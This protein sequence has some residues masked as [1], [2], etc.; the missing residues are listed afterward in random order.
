MELPC[1]TSP[2]AVMG[3]RDKIYRPEEK[4]KSPNYERADARCQPMSKIRRG[5]DEFMAMA[6][7]WNPPSQCQPWEATGFAVAVLT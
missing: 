1:S 6:Y 5:G 3:S 2:G 4:Q 7:P